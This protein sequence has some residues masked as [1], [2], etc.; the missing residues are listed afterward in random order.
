MIL[1]ATV[2]AAAPYGVPV[3]MKTRIGIDDDHQTYLDAGRIAEQAGCAAIAL[4][5]RTAQQAYSGQADWGA[6][7]ALKAH[8]SIP[9][10]GNGD[11]WEAADALRMV[12]RDRSRRGGDRTRLPGPALAV[13]RPGGCVLPGRRRA[14]AARPWARS[15]RRFAGTPSCWPRCPTSRTGCADLRKHM[16][17]YFKGFPVGG[18]LRRRLAMVSSLA[19]LD[20]PAW[21]AGP[22]RALP[23]DRARVAARPAG[24]AAD[25][26]SRCPRAGWTTRR[27]APRPRRRG[28][29]H[30]RWLTRSR[31]G[32]RRGR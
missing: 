9:V 10:L 3:T 5:G 2:G 25:A 23:A 15:A 6:I 4:H 30:L 7:A 14:D 28:A 27:G 13:P 22:G 16:A 17:W 1:E 32:P 12:R 8:V 20:R 24:C 31:P 21:P 11:I 19:E 29:G 26:G 18:E